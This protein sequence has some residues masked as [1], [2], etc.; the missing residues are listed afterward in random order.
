MEQVEK[1]EQSLSPAKLKDWVQDE[2][3]SLI[4]LVDIAHTKEKLTELANKYSTIKITRENY[5]KEAAA[6]ESELRQTR[7]L[8]QN[9]HKKNNK[10]LN[11]VKREEKEVFDSLISIVEVVEK[12]I[13]EEIVAIDLVVKKEKEEAEKAE[14]LRIQ[15]LN[16]NLSGWEVNFSKALTAIKTDSELA[17]YDKMLEEFEAIFPNF[18]EFEFK[19]KRLHAVFKG[20]RSEAVDTI[21]AIKKQEDDKKA[22]EEEKA[23]IEAR[24]EKVFNFRIGQLE[25][26]GFVEPH[27]YPVIFNDELGLK[28]TNE[29]ILAYD[30]VDW[31]IF[32]DEIDQKIKDHATKN[33]QDAKDAVIK[34]RNEWNELLDVFKGFG[35]D[36]TA[37]KLKKDEVPTS[38]DIEKLKEATKAIQAQKRMLKLEGVRSEMKL[39]KDEFISSIQLFEEKVK[40]TKFEHPETLSIFQNLINKV[41]VAINE[42]LGEVINE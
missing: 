11:D 18:M 6:A 17:E 41:E 24:K 3:G 19:A 12:R 32:L 33:E 21:A 15:K 23:K 28:L 14:E 39:L 10:H 13:K 27:D 7:Y 25:A 35:G 30:E 5:K 42:V 9:I 8:L 16:D 1:I 34:A 22:V 20:R 26:R 38:D 40:S 37:W 31:T 4:R 2:D 29:D 36:T